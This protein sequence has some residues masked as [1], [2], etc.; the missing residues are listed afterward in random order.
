MTGNAV[1]PKGETNNATTANSVTSKNKAKSTGNLKCN[2][3]YRVKS[4]LTKRFFGITSRC[5]GARRT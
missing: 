4:G 5:V 1:T 2:T 3:F